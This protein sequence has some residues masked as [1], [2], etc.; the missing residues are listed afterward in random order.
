MSARKRQLDT[1]MEEMKREQAMRDFKKKVQE[2]GLIPTEAVPPK[3]KE[4]PLAMKVMEN[5]TVDEFGRTKVD[6]PVAGKW[7]FQNEKKET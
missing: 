6:R 5:D 7:S 1:Y 4:V 3:K 2:K